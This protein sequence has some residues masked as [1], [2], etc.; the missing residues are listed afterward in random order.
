MLAG[1]TAIQVLSKDTNNEFVYIIIAVL[2]GCYCMIGGLGTTFYVSYLNTAITFLS[3]TVYIIYTSFYPSPDTEDV[4]LPDNVYNHVVCLNAPESNYDRSFFT[5]RS[6][7]GIIYGAV[8]LFMATS[9]GFC[10]QANWQSRIAAKPTQGILGFYLAAF[11]WFILPLALS[12]TVTTSYLSMSAINGTHLL[13]DF[14]IDNGT[15]E[16]ND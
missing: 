1:R 8:F 3:V 6:R 2:F 10:D 14:E 12:F 11:L 7:A 4:S 9:N 16:Y 15:Y 5:F 13:T